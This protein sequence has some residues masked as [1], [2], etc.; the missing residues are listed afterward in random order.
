LT[1]AK[2]AIVT[3]AGRGIGAG[4]ARAMAQAGYAVIVH[5]RN[6]D[7]QPLIETIPG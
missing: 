7:P 6:T 2:V 5:Y 1:A 3:G 4:I